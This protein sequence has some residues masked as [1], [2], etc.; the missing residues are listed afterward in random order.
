[1]ARHYKINGKLV[2]ANKRQIKGH[3]TTGL[4]EKVGYATLEDAN[5]AI[6]NM[7]KVHTANFI[8]Y[9]CPVCEKYHI[10]KHV[11]DDEYNFKDKHHKPKAIDLVAFINANDK[12]LTAE[13]RTKL[14][15]FLKNENK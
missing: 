2:K 3:F 13:Q 1:M 8:A 12:P 15:N 14:Q 4:K 10:G 5:V 11:E 9:F 6:E 7:S